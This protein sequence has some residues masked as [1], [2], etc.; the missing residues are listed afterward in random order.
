MKKKDKQPHLLYPPLEQLRH[1][2]TFRGSSAGCDN[3]RD[4]WFFHSHTKRRRKVSKS[5]HLAF[6]DRILTGKSCTEPAWMSRRKCLKFRRSSAK[7]PRPME[8]WVKVEF[9]YFFVRYLAGRRAR[10]IFGT[11]MDGW[12]CGSEVLKYYVCPVNLKLTEFTQ[13]HWCD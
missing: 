7:W 9:L 8:R 5:S 2:T 11:V 3:E 12:L 4:Q 13:M 10:I 6:S 1:T